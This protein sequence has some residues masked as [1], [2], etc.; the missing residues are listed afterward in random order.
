MTEFLPKI[1]EY[2]KDALVYA[3]HLQDERPGRT[4]I[5]IISKR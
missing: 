2:A 4:P 5:L 1:R 3:A